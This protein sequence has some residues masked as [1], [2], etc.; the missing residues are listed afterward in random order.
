[1][2]SL[3]LAVL[4]WVS[5]HAADPWSEKR[6]AAAF[7]S[8][9][10][11]LRV[12]RGEQVLERTRGLKASDRFEPCS[13][14]K[15]PHALM[16]LEMG[17]ITS[18]TVLRC[19]GHECHAAH[20]EIRLARAIAESCVGYFRLCARKIGKAREEAWLIRLGY[21]ITTVHAPVDS[22]WLHG[23]FRISAAEQLTWIR[24]FYSEPLPVKGEH[25]DL[26]RELSLKT[27]TSGYTLHGKTGSSRPGPDGHGWFVGRIT[28]PDGRVEFIC[29][30]VKGKG[31]DGQRV[32]AAIR[33]LLD[34][35]GELEQ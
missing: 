34:G 29:G 12:Q 11:C 26:V 3:L 21:P 9:D 31:G 4:G 24:R 17:I 19:D 5:L 35:Q 15:L 8:F 13:T 33:Y 23:D 1:M 25:L 28:Y 30:L 27:R 7:G 10:Y 32:E 20:G 18:T 6:V 2:R 16:A 22:F 14:F